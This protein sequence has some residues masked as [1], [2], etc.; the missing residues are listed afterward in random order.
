MRE[1]KLRERKTHRKIEEKIG[2][3]KTKGSKSEYPLYS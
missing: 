1:K 3:I 2:E